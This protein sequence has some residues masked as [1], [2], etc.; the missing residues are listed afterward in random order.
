MKIPVDVILK[1]NKFR[2]DLDLSVMMMQEHASNIA[3]G[4]QV[5][6]SLKGLEKCKKLILECT[7]KFDHFI[8]EKYG[9][10]KHYSEAAL[11]AQRLATASNCDQQQ[12]ESSAVLPTG[13]F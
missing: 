3:K 13:T 8:R 4:Y 10:R 1:Y 12:P 6:K 11:Q 7:K 5:D 9:A 2:N